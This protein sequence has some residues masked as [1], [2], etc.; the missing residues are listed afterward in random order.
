MDP[1]IFIDPGYGTMFE[2][3]GGE[4]PSCTDPGGDGANVR[5]Y[6]DVSKRGAKYKFNPY[7]GVAFTKASKNFFCI[8]DGIAKALANLKRPTGVS[9]CQVKIKFSVYCNTAA[10]GFSVGLSKSKTATVPD[11][12]GITTVAGSKYQ[13]KYPDNVD[14]AEDNAG[15][16]DNGNFAKGLHNISLLIYSAGGDVTFG[17]AVDDNAVYLTQGDDM[18]PLEE[19][20]LGIWF[21]S[22]DKSYYV[23]N[24]IA[25]YKGPDFGSNA[26][27]KKIIPPETY[28]Y[29]LN[30][31]HPSENKNTSFT[32]D[33]T[34]GK[35]GQWI[36]R[37]NGDKLLQT[38][39]AFDLVHDIATEN[40]ESLLVETK[41]EGYVTVGL[42][43]TDE[44]KK[45]AVEQYGARVEVATVVVF[46]DPAYKSKYFSRK[47]KGLFGT[48][49]KDGYG[50]IPTDPDVNSTYCIDLQQHD[51]TLAKI[52][53]KDVGWQISGS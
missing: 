12:L 50:E 33:T 1:V 19:L 3:T 31:S 38:I 28:L 13:F 5:G 43:S 17:I 30:L 47:V 4:K 45:L 48:A 46:G 22:Q 37:M 51:T 7:C 2:T 26:Y 32:P 8:D 42:D 40:E 52:N 20:Q 21:P 23:S 44:R 39:N 29:A 34:E 15:T 14:L 49:Q 27:D 24:V 36:G 53:G 16:L 25:C 10:D 11:Y 9:K 41:D 6:A 18:I 35:E